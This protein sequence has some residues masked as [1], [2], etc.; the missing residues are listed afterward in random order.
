MGGCIVGLAQFASLVVESSAC[1]SEW[2]SLLF[3]LIGWGAAAGVLGSMVCIPP[4]SPITPIDAIIGFGLA[5]F[6]PRSDP[7]TD[8][9]LYGQEMD[10]AG[11]IK[12]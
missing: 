3:T 1:R 4:L 7:A 6:S 10:S 8:A 11:R 2:T 12:A 5:R 9:L